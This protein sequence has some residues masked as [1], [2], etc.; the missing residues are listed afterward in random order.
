MSRSAL[1][2]LTI[3]LFVVGV[4]LVFPFSST[5]TRIFGIAALFAFIVCGL[6]VIADPADLVDGEPEADSD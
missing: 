6:F 3:A 5:L 4:G 2:K 1:A